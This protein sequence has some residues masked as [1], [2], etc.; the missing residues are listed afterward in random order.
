MSF[1]LLGSQFLFLHLHVSHPSCMYPD[2]P[3]A[4]PGPS[5]LSDSTLV[6]SLPQ[7]RNAEN[8][9][10]AL[11]EYEPEMG[12]V[13]R[14]DRKSVQRIKARDIVPGD[15][16]EVAG[17][18]WNGCFRGEALGLRP[19]REQGTCQPR[20]SISEDGGVFAS[21]SQTP[22]GSLQDIQATAPLP[23]RVSIGTASPVP[24]AADRPPSPLPSA[25]TC[26]QQ[27]E[28]SP[29]QWPHL[30]PFPSLAPLSFHPPQAWSAF[31]LDPLVPLRPLKGEGMGVEGSGGG[32]GG[33]VDDYSHHH[34]R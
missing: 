27:V 34:V 6:C 33:G 17:K 29:C 23:A 25:N 5:S 28:A 30:H 20:S 26:K 8:A 7:E 10:E 4:G 12:K 32:V 18:G 31:S 13:Y 1:F 22:Q 21:P 11:K 14:A 19:R 9:I 15:I 3:P 24:E 2:Q 16:V